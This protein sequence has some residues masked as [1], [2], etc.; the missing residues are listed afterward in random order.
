MN[1]HNA[2]YTVPKLAAPCFKHV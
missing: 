2:I 1:M